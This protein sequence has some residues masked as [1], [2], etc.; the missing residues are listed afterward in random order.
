MVSHSNEDL[1][2]M[3]LDSYNFS[4]SRNQRL[5]QIALVNVKERGLFGFET[6]KYVSEMVERFRVPREE[7]FA[8]SLNQPAY[9]GSDTLLEDVTPSFQY[10]EETDLE[11]SIFSDRISVDELSSIIGDHLDPEY[12]EIFRQLIDGSTR[13]LTF[14]MSPDEILLDIPLIKRRLVE[15]RRMFDFNGKL[16]IP[17]R[18]VVKVSL[19]SDLFVVFGTR[20]FG[21]DP[22]SFFRNYLSVYGSLAH[23]TELKRFDRGLYNSLLRYGQL[24]EAIPKIR[25]KFKIRNVKPQKPKKTLFSLEERVDEELIIH[26]HG[27]VLNSRVIH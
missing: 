26:N 14:S 1:I 20:R 6:Y 21:R 10:Y 13:N 5:Y 3:V 22:L 19:D 15:L 25:P 4:E 2:R 8:R 17:R 24:E 7:R 12:V 18:P 11:V 23:Q 9:R 27:F 16:L